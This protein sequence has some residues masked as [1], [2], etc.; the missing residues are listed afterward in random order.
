MQKDFFF[1]PLSCIPPVSIPLTVC[2]SFA[3]VE[4]A[5]FNILW[6]YTCLYWKLQNIIPMYTFLAGLGCGWM[7][8]NG[9]LNLNWNFL[10]K[11]KR[12]YKI[13]KG[14]FLSKINYLFLNIQK[15]STNKIIIPASIHTWSC[16]LPVLIVLNSHTLRQISFPLIFI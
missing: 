8:S 1:L 5:F 10:N 14:I 12:F 15:N 2:A 4:N 7:W 6:I 11:P 13:A 16:L 3:H 9:C